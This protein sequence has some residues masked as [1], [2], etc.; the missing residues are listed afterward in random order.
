MTVD[1]CALCGDASNTFAVLLS[2]EMRLRRIECNALAM[3]CVQLCS[4]AVVL[5]LLTRHQYKSSVYVFV[6]WIVSHK[7]WLVVVKPFG[8]LRHVLTCSLKQKPKLTSFLLVF[9]AKLPWFAASHIVWPYGILQY[10][11]W[12]RESLVRCCGAFCAVD[13]CQEWN[14][15]T[16][17]LA[18]CGRAMVFMSRAALCGATVSSEGSPNS[19]LNTQW[20]TDEVD[21]GFR[22]CD[23]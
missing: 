8:V 7:S 16:V 14:W 22:F 21:D 11:R 19:L 23:S 5:H 2:N 10:G 20:L 9:F 4:S 17:S 6:A 1:S 15:T 3:Q 12:I 13:K 18:K